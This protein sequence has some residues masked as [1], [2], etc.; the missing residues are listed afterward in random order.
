MQ[1]KT[2]GL[3]QPE[4]ANG[5]RDVEIRLA[6]ERGGAGG[7][8]RNRADEDFMMS[9]KKD[10]VRRWVETT[11]V[12]KAPRKASRVVTLPVTSANL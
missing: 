11:L 10:L 5:Y 3:G 1:L 8:K 12:S 6:S 7:R 4:G 2:Y 9:G